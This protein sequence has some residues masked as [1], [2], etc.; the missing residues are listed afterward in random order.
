MSRKIQ[1][2]LRAIFQ[3][4]YPTKKQYEN[5]N[6]YCLFWFDIRIINPESQL[7]PTCIFEFQ[8]HQDW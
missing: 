4:K 6:S 7:N 1:N 3:K 8:V 5:K 2:I